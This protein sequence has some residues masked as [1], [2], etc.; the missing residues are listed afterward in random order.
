MVDNTNLL[1]IQV[2]ARQKKVAPTSKQPSHKEQTDQWVI[3]EKAMTT[4]PLIM[5][6]ST[7]EK[8]TRSQSLDG[9]Q[10]YLLPALIVFNPVF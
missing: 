4:T 6:P 3:K 2:N 7:S 8:I 10:G 1:I 9:F 5:L